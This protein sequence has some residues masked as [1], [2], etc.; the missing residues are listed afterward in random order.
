MISEWWHNA[1]PQN[2]KN[3]TPGAMYSSAYQPKVSRVKICLDTFKKH[4]PRYIT[5]LI[6]RKRKFESN[7]KLFSPTKIICFRNIM[8]LPKYCDVLKWLLS[9]WEDNCFSFSPKFVLAQFKFIPAEFKYH[10]DSNGLK[11]NLHTPTKDRCKNTFT[12]Y[13]LMY[14]TLPIWTP[15]D[16]IAQNIL[17]RVE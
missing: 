10:R 15:L 2:L 4:K 11:I 3:I 9:Y 6:P 1:A 16:I 12:R 5:S 8:T 7:F 17:Y 13:V 14:L